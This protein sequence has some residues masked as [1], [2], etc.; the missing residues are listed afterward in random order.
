M[1]YEDEDVM[2]WRDD[3]IQRGSKQNNPYRQKHPDE[4][5]LIPPH[6]KS[7]EILGTQKSNLKRIE[8]STNTHIVYNENEGQIELWGARKNVES[9]I[10]Q[11]SSIAENLLTDKLQRQKEFKVK[12]WAK[13]EKA[14]TKKQLEKK[15]RREE[16]ERKET[17]YRGFPESSNPFSAHF[18][19]PDHTIDTSRFVGE[20]EEVLNPVRAQTKSYIWFEPGPNRFTASADNIEAVEAGI[21]RVKNLYL[22]LVASRS[23]P[24]TNQNVCKGWIYHLIQQPKRSSCLVRLSSP[25]LGF[26]KPYDMPQNCKF[27]ILER[28]LDGEIE[29][30]E[31][32]IKND[33]DKPVTDINFVK[34]IHRNNIERINDALK[35]ALGIIHLFDEEIKMRIRFGHICFT[36]FPRD[37]L[38]AIDK[39]SEK[40]LSDSR[41][42]SKFSTCMAT[43]ND[44]LKP[45]RKFLDEKDNQRWDGI[46]FSEFRICVIH[47]NNSKLKYT[48]DVQFNQIGRDNKKSDDLKGESKIGLWNAVTNEKNVMEINM[49]CLDYKH[50][51]K[52][53]IQ[54]AK[55]VN[56]DKFK[57]H[58][59]FAHKLKLSPDKNRLIYINTKDIVVSSVCEKTK[60]KYWWKYHY[61]VEITKYEYWKLNESPIGVEI[62]LDDRPDDISWGVT[63]YKKSWDESFAHNSNL[64]IGEVPDWHPT[65]ILEGESGR[66][67]NLLEDIEEFMSDVLKDSIDVGDY[68]E[69][70]SDED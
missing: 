54:T 24:M 6:L 63:L 11:W 5:W 26:V 35:D 70:S 42:S 32:K 17:D 27:V 58:G 43:G 67:D 2:N 12:G 46:P 64:D 28:V 51:W 59:V 61:V 1:N 40:V 34:N 39:L 69:D 4:V 21:L 16:R 20:R 60:Y 37:K 52:L 57:A 55:R 49:A 45:I 9:A 62:I 66:I 31:K 25:P 23:I 44:K 53:T 68:I 30:G 19:L 22:K 65:D 3:T 7:S 50:S 33:E 36:D 48:F 47:P 56:N 13:P 18:Y 8:D 38:W 14:L 41:L 29:T 10:R 15:K